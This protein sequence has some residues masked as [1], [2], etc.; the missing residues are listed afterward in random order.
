ML[1]EDEGGRDDS[2]VERGV[3]PLRISFSSL[4][5]CNASAIYKRTKTKMQM[6]NFRPHLSRHSLED[7]LEALPAVLRRRRVLL[8][9]ALYDDV[10]SGRHRHR[11]SL[12]QLGGARYYPARTKKDILQFEKKCKAC[13]VPVGPFQNAERFLQMA[14]ELA[15]DLL[16]LLLRGRRGYPPS[17][18][19][20]DDDFSQ[21]F[22][23]KALAIHVPDP[24]KKT[25]TRPP[26]PPPRSPPA[27][28]PP[29]CPS[30]RPAPPRPGWPPRSSPRC[31][32]G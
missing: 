6:I 29:P 5:A 31:C 10:C 17:G 13:F 15:L 22:T 4:V 1:P 32:G 26:P 8:L 24:W 11:R 30:R 14:D 9:L 19:L 25:S 18:I 3:E 23:K 2:L 16:R 7:V 27:P 20:E 12:L 28:P 21:D